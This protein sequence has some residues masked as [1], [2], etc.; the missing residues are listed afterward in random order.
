MSGEY[1][2]P[3]VAYL[4]KREGGPRIEY[5]DLKKF[6][7][8]PPSTSPT[9]Q[10]VRDAVRSIRQSKAMLIVPGDD[11]CRSAGPFFKN[12]IA[13]SVEPARAEPLPH[14]PVPRKNRHP[15]P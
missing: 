13:T 11:D 8:D 7:G 15:H 5:A 6:F 1:I 4:L 9:L 12:P 10:Q 3:E 14:Q 2:V